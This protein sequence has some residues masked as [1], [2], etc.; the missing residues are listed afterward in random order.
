LRL[1]GH[2]VVT[3]FSARD[4]LSMA[5][6]FRPDVIFC[7]IGL[8]GPD[9]GLTVAAR[10]REQPCFDQTLLVALTGSDGDAHE[11]R[12][13]AAGFDYHLVKPVGLDVMES[14]IEKAPVAR[15]GRRANSITS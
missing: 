6:E 4:A 10:L 13:Y 1:S 11:S 15:E 14:V 3:V 9:D 8:P 7:D 12:V 2:A 5:L